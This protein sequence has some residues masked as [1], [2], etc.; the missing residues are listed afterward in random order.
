MVQQAKV[1]SLRENGDAEI[2]V[3]RESACGHDC[4][5]CAGCGM[6]AA[7]IRAYAKNPKGAQIGD[8]VQVES[9]SRKILA[10]AGV[11]YLLPL[12]LFFIVYFTTFSLTASDA[13]AISTGIIGFIVGI[14]MSIFLNRREEKKSTISMVITKVLR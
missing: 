7:P 10:I 1:L 4:S 14:L 6:Q 2:L 12:A 3:E 13:T 9:A 8:W 5:S 11:V